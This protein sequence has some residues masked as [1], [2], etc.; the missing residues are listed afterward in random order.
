VDTSWTRWLRGTLLIV[1]ALAH[2]HVRG[3]R[4]R[5]EGT[6]L[7]RSLLLFPIPL[8]QPILPL[9]QPILLFLLVVALRLLPLVEGVEV[10][11]PV[12]CPRLVHLARTR[13]EPHRGDVEAALGA[14]VAVRVAPEAGFRSQNGFTDLMFSVVAVALKISK[15]SHG[16]DFVISRFR[17]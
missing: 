2:A 16:G 5:S 10:G 9:H 6:T 4:L 7:A 13:L 14:E 15:V 12:Q 1:S 11:V 17:A 3:P 8:H